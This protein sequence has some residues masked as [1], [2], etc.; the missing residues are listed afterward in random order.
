MR[1]LDSTAEPNYLRDELRVLTEDR[2][3][4]FLYRERKGRRGSGGGG[5]MSDLAG[6]LSS[7]GGR[8]V[9]SSE[10]ISTRGGPTC[11]FALYGSMTF[12]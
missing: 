6:S 5:G 10:E 9:E 11:P 7:G 2:R 8:H 1:R 12:Y 4:G 3:V